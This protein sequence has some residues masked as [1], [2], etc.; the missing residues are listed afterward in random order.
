[1]ENKEYDSDYDFQEGKYVIIN[2]K[3]SK[4]HKN[5]FKIEKVN[6]NKNKSKIHKLINGN[7]FDFFHESFLLPIDLLKAGDYIYHKK[8][9]LLVELK[10]DIVEYSMV[11]KFEVYVETRP[12][13]IYKDITDFEVSDKAL[14]KCINRFEEIKKPIEPEKIK[15]NNPFEKTMKERIQDELGK[16]Y[17]E[18]EDKA[19]LK[20]LQ[21]D[22]Y[23]ENTDPNEK[24]ISRDGGSS[25]LTTDH[26]DAFRYQNKYEFLIPN[27]AIDFTEDIL[28]GAINI[29]EKSARV[30][31][32]I[33]AN[34]DNCMEFWKK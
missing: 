25:T 9:G 1:M 23:I 34:S 8:Y 13:T 6:V 21:E 31:G 29:A 30:S 2:W 14:K 33:Y 22:C 5:I 24:M 10:H 26:L 32:W 3:E 16:H 28:Y 20:I 7:Y 15:I 27:K 12:F 17:I 4:L 18:Q 11:N 19:L